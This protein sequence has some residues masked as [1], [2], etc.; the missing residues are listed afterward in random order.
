PS[1][2]L[3]NAADADAAVFPE[4]STIS[5]ATR[6]SA[7]SD[8]GGVLTSIAHDTRAPATTGS[9]SRFD[10]SSSLTTRSA[11]DSGPA[12]AKWASIGRSRLPIRADESLAATLNVYAPG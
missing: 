5:N 4:P 8:P 11:I 6:V 1:L 12:G 3:T 10:A 2:E 9:T 7:G